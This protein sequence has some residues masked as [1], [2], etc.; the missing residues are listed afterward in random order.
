VRRAIGENGLLL[1]RTGRPPKIA[2]PFRLVGEPFGKLISP[3]FADADGTE[4]HIEI[5]ANGQQFIACGIHPDTG[6][7]YTWSQA[8]RSVPY[9]SLPPLDNKA[10]HEIFDKALAVL[11]KTGWT[12]LGADKPKPTI[13]ERAAAT[14]RP[15]IDI[16][17]RDAAYGAAALRNAAEELATTPEGGR[18]NVLNAKAY[19]LGRQVA[20]GRL[21]KEEVEEELYKAAEENG[22]TQDAGGP[23]GVKRTIKSGLDDGMAR[24]AAPLGDGFD[25]SE[26]NSD[27]SDTS[28]NSNNAKAD[29][30]D[31]KPPPLPFIDM[32]RWDAGPLPEREWAVPDRIPLRQTAIMSGEG[33]VGKSH[34]AL[35]LCAAHALGRD[36]L[37]SLPEPGP[38]I[39]VDAEDDENEL[40][41]RLGAIARHY[42]VSFTDLI[43]GGLHLI[44]LVGKDATMATVSLRGKVEPT[45]VYKQLLEAAGDI[46]PKMIGIASGS[47]VFAGK[48]NDRGQVQQF[49]GLMTRIA[50]AATGSV[51]LITHPSLVGINTDTGLSGSTQWHNAVRARCY[52]KG[53]K[54]DAGE[55]PDGDL[56]E[57]VFKK[58]QYSALPDSI[59]LS[60]QG[61]MF[62][63]LPGVSNLDRLA[64]QAKTQEVFLIL[65]A[66][67][68][69]ENR[70]VSAHKGH[71][72]APAEFAAEDEA[73]KAGVTKSDLR[74]AMLALFKGGEIYNEPHGRPGRERFHI[75]RKP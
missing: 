20:A 51:N 50:M 3:F 18:N 55:Q 42:G 74:R 5:L 57:L 65:L 48:E 34:T 54:A 15:P 58:A 49:V 26:D 41:I 68:T 16:S 75:A 28:D 10:A 44:S 72:F 63:P 1:K 22:L 4:N 7:A 60:Y 53:V 70:H 31:N 14:V 13:C 39:F 19:T 45:G 9:N 64:R 69:R 56:R 2:I 37:L 6:A 43:K 30:G 46:Q 29:T 33:G 40:H 36:W 35:H 38:A 52:M 12:E 21:A 71:G 73:K 66:R 23:L 67:Y 8:I 62:L 47:N 27:S 59:V 24:P 61:G 17:D 25:T 32:S 11:R